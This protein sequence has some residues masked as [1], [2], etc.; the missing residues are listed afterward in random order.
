MNFKRHG[1]SFFCLPAASQSDGG[2]SLR[3]IAN[4]S[5]PIDPCGGSFFLPSRYI[6]KRWRDFASLDC[7]LLIAN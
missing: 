6:E 7:Q 3:L 1:G 4:C 2:T 5:L